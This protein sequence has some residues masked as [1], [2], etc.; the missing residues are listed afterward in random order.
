M[1]WPTLTCVAVI[2]I[3]AVTGG[4]SNRPL[5]RRRA[6]EVITKLDAFNKTAF[7][8]IA[9]ESPFM[10][11][12]SFHCMTQAEV[13]RHPVNRLLVK[14][15]WVRYESRRTTVGFQ[16]QADCPVMLLT[17]AGKAASA[18]WQAH[19]GAPGKGTTWT[20]PIGERALEDVT[21]LTD[22]PDGS[23]LVEYTWKWR[24]NSLGSTLARE[25]SQ[26]R[27][28]FDR[29]RKGTADCRLW[30]DGWRCTLTTMSTSFEDVGQFW[31]PYE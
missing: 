16:E 19:P 20:I 12:M 27:A 10:G 13:E 9:I 25:V 29:S 15:G 21:G 2:L 23:K 4:C 30:D 8:Q 3:A 7:F 14:L 6:G 26:A 11:S 5:D 17:D 18:D 28:F 22:A 1:R 24:P 31:V